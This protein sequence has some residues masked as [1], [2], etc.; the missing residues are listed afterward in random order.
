MIR[1]DELYVRSWRGTGGTWWKTAQATHTGHIAAG[2]VEADVTFAPVGDPAVNDRVD[3]AY[4]TKYGHYSG[5]V[6]PM[7]GEQA[8]AT[9]LRLAPRS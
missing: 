8:R 5:Y 4:Q 2:G 6:E 1:C 7:V 9:T 3:A